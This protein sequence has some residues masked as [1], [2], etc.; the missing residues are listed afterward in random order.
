MTATPSGRRNRVRCS[1]GGAGLIA[2]WLR[3]GRMLYRPQQP[4][5]QPPVARPGLQQHLP[6]HPPGRIPKG[7]GDYDHVVQGADHGQE[8]GQQVHWGQYPQPGQDHGGLGLEG[9][10]GV[11]PQPPSQGDAGGQEPGQVLQ[12]PGRQAGG[13][14]DQQRPQ[15]DHDR[16]GGQEELEP[17]DH[18]S[19]PTAAVRHKPTLT[20]SIQTMN[21]PTPTSDEPPS[22]VGPRT[23]KTD[24]SRNTAA[25]T[26]PATPSQRPT[27]P[28]RQIAS[29]SA[30]TKA[31]IAQTIGVR[32]CSSFRAS[33]AAGWLA[34]ATPIRAVS[35]ALD[36]KPMVTNAPPLI[37]TATATVSCP[38]RQMTGTRPARNPMKATNASPPIAAMRNGWPGARSV[39]ALLTTA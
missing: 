6:R 8:L 19:P 34:S 36:T 39:V 31:V 9:H 26:W 17:A 5:Q 2:S 28:V 25:A 7:Q 35:A 13:Q 27:R 12:Q 16:G 14:D 10:P 37:A 20:A 15:A 3:F 29:E 11:G 32:P 22:G 21:S 33:T 18:H 1:S 23:L 30:A 38:A 24:P 4:F